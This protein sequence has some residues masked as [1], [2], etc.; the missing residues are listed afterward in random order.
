MRQYIVTGMSCAACAARVEKAVKG[1][2]GVKDCAVS[3]LTGSMGVLGEAKPEDVVAAVEKAGYG[4]SPKGDGGREKIP[5][6][7]GEISALKRRLS[8]SLGFL[9]ALMYLSMGVPMMGWPLPDFFEGNIL[10]QGIL[11]MLLS[12]SVM[13]I[14]QAFFVG[15]TKSL[16]SGGPNMDTLVA[17]GSFASFGYSFAAL[18][19]MTGAAGDAEAMAAYRGDFYFESA[20]MILALITFGKMLEARSKGKT[21]DALKSLGALAPL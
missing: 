17:L 4:A 16:L 12:A 5:E 1:V 9:A 21:A 6:S 3:L 14:N 7:F 8:A 13:V 18:L 10:A 19:L 2:P 15:G 20:A 11:Q